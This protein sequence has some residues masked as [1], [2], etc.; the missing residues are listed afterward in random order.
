MRMNPAPLVA[1]SEPNHPDL[2][3]V[4][5][6]YV[7]GIF[8][9]PGRGSNWTARAVTWTHTHANWFA[10]RVEYVCGFFTRNARQRAR[11]TALR[12]VLSAYLARGA[13]VRIVAHSNGADVALDALAQL[14]WPVIDE[15][16]LFAPACHEDCE[17]S[18]LN[19]VRSGLIAIYIAERDRAMVLAGTWLGRALGFGTLGKSG[20][21]NA[22]GIYPD[23][24]RY[25][26]FG[27]ADWWK[28]GQF[29]LCM[30]A[31]TRA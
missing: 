31:V 19:N 20:P 23:V 12:H 14:E 29:E 30:E 7:G 13:R 16:H 17:K 18:G 25:P 1:A 4:V 3:P 24:R 11:A 5:I 27:H 15:L 21:V 9:F 8:T 2:R 26:S 22:R 6:V 28:D 10:E